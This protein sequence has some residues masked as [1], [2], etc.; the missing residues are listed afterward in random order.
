MY[1]CL[2]DN[3]SFDVQN[4]SILYIKMGYPRLENEKQAELVQQL[5][6]CLPGRP[7]PQQNRQVLVVL[8]G[9]VDINQG[10]ILSVKCW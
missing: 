10:Y 4:F 9:N 1:R 7:E 2:I 8:V 3:M 5:V 6:A